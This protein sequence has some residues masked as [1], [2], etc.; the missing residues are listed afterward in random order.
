MERTVVIFQR[1]DD[2]WDWHV[3]APNGEVVFG[4]VQGFT[5]ESDAHE[6]AVRE[7]TGTYEYKVVRKD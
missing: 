4:S 1:D 6:A 3:V 5:T 7:T 2:L